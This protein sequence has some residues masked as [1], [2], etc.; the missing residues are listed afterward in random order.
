M[1]NSIIY[2]SDIQPDITSSGSALGMIL[3]VIIVYALI[4]IA[5]YIVSSIFLGKVFRKA[6]VEPWKAWVPVLNTWKILEIGGQQGFWAIL[7]FV[8]IANIV[9]LV[10]VI[11]AMHNINLKLG[12]GVGMTV[13]AVFLPIVWLIVL[14]VSNNSWNESL[15]APRTDNSSFPT[16]GGQPIPTNTNMSTNGF[17][18]TVSSQPEA[19]NSV[20]EPASTLATTEQAASVSPTEEGVQAII[21]EPYQSSIPEPAPSVEQPTNQDATPLVENPTA[22]NATIDQVDQTQ[23]PQQPH[24]TDNHLQ[25]PAPRV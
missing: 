20:A 9:A 15:G 16:E 11:I 19:M 3:G 7:T 23:Q 13:L 2:E 1:N 18:A 10:F 25:P 8:P 4:M 22:Y 6:G 21:P 5:I 14:A 12:N 24:P 17:Q